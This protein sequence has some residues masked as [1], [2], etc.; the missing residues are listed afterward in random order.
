MKNVNWFVLITLL[1]SL[2]IIALIIDKERTPTK[3]Y[4]TTTNNLFEFVQWTKQTDK[5]I[6][7]GWVVFAINPNTCVDVYEYKSHWFSL[8][9]YDFENIT[10]QNN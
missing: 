5:T 1:V 8:T 7:C 4:I 10:P 3:T 2:A 6:W 9:H